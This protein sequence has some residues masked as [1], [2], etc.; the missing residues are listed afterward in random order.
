MNSNPST[1]DYLL[2]ICAGSVDD[3]ETAEQAGAD[4]IELNSALALGGLT[5]SR[6]ML[7]LALAGTRLPVI[8]MC[9]P[10]T[11]GFCYTAGEYRTLLADVQGC[12]EAGSAGVAFGVLTADRKID[13]RRCREIVQQCGGRQAVFHRAFDLTADPLESIRTLVDCGVNRVMTS[14]G[15][16]TAVQGRELIAAL[17]EKFDGAI[18]ILAAGGIRP[19]NV[20]QLVEAGIRQIHAGPGRMQADHSQPPA[21]P[22]RF[23]GPLSDNPAL[24]RVVC[25]LTV[26][27][28]ANPETG[29]NPDKP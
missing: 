12:L 14:G 4:R 10:R 16:A 13:Q 8:A 20:Q 29:R 27:Q 2:E 21:G 24:Y 22:V 5:P 26:R 18:E 6:G 9:R 7:D 28:M 1:R 11:S 17:V 15:Q 19:G 23:D 25:G 3:V